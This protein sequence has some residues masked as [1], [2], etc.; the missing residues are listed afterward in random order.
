MVGFASNSLLCRGALA[1]EH[2][3]AASFTALRV[4]GGAAVLALLARTRGAPAP[5]AGFAWA[6]GL[7]LF[8][9]AAG[10]SFA[11]ERIPAG[12]G[13]LLLFAAVQLT[14]IGAG[15]RAG[16][17]PRVDQ[18]TGV[19][20]SLAGLVV[21]ARPGLTRPDTAG[22]LLMIAAGAAWGVF[23]LRGQRT[24]FDPVAANA[25]SFARALLPALAVG[26]AA[27]S[28][29]WTR[30]DGTGALLALASGGVASGLFYAIWYA[31]LR[32]LS[33]TAAAVVQLSVPVLAAA[34]G[35]LLLG[36][37]LTVRLVIASA[38]VLGGI[39]LAARRPPRS[40]P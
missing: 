21:L 37:R 25:A 22:T 40:G 28:A 24:S 7:A 34:G 19:A 2:A 16:E 10:F 5:P 1:G 6:S 35:V 23:S 33:A 13:A 27:W 18:W 39:A 3:D 9:Y 17:R 14:M 31:A 38:L 32:G 26:A 4:A 20:L 11:Y 15:L 8:V 29:G 30:L 12:A 36:E